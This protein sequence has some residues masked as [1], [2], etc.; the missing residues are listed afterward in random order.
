MNVSLQQ[1]I[2]DN[3]CIINHLNP[4]VMESRRQKRISSLIQ[5]DVGTILQK[6]GASLF[7]AKPF[8]T[9]TDVY[10]TPDLAIARLYLSVYNVDDRQQVVDDLEANIGE[11][12][13]ELGNR[14]RHQVRR[15]P[16]LEVYL[17]DTLDKVFRMD[18]IF[19]EIRN[20]DQGNNNQ[21]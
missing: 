4:V 18:K 9:V 14:I 7:G 5:E 20:K 10:V 13:Y 1:G 15:V 6:K 17:D 8:V 19:K 11:L 21:E 2:G 3:K 16:E 12:R